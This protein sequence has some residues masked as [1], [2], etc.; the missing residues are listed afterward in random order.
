MSP[1]AFT[2][3]PHKCPGSALSINRHLVMSSRDRFLLS[4]MP[5]FV[6]YRVE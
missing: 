1:A 2:A 3:S 4:A 5:F 6:V